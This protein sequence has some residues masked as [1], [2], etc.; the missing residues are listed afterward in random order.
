MT[1][2]EA[3]KI[4]GLNEQDVAIVEGL[5]EYK[6]LLEK[7]MATLRYKRDIAKAKKELEAVNTL[8]A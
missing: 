5:N 3:R 2:A 4:L 1:K 8:L 6:K 7:Q